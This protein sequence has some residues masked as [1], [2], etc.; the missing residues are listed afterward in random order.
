[1]R[2]AA[3]VVLLL[4]S[5]MLFAQTAEECEK[6][7]PTERDGCYLGRARTADECLPISDL[8]VREQC[9][10]VIAEQYA[11]SYRD[12]DRLYSG[13]QPICYARVTFMKDR[14]H[15]ACEQLQQ[16][17]RGEC[18]IYYAIHN[19]PGTII[20]CGGIPP[21]YKDK[22]IERFFE[23]ASLQSESDCAAFGDY[24]GDRCKEYFNSKTNIQQRFVLFLESAWNFVS[25]QWTVAGISLI[26]F[27]IFL[28]FGARVLSRALRMS[29]R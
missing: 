21:N 11:T 17:F 9:F 7:I 2:N 5:V 13:F 26:I 4:L 29:K 15:L 12:C 27:L 24:Y 16:D 14:N 8:H 22:C 20:S 6:M 28:V 19:P 18:Y 3:P 1:M 10:T 23:K 25:S